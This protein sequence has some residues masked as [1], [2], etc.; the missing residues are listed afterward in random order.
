MKL[1]KLRD[2]ARPH[3]NFQIGNGNS[4][5]FWLDTCWQHTTIMA[6]HCD[7]IIPNS[8]LTPLAKIGDFIS[9]GINHHT[10]RI[11]LGLIDN[12]HRIGMPDFDPSKADRMLWVDNDKVT[13]RV[14]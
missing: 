7:P 6:S 9:N 13:T 3:I 10:S 4:I 1:L 12:F 5:F 2:I 14:I 11:L 8:G